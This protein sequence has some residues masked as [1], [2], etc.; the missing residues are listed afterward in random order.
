MSIGEVIRQHR[1]QLNLTQA[2]LAEIIGVSAQAI[3]KWETGAGMPDIFLLVPLAEALGITTDQL[4]RSTK[5]RREFDMLWERALRT[6]GQNGQATLA[7]SEAALAEFPRDRD[8][9]FRASWDEAQ[10]AKLTEDFSARQT[11]LHRAMNYGERLLTLEPNHESIKEHLVRVYDDLGFEEEAV[12]MAYRCENSERAL[13]WCLKGEDLRRHRLKII[14]R[15]LQ[16]LLNELIV[17]EPKLL[18][19]AEKL[20][21]ARE[22][23]LRLREETANP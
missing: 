14:D 9:L 13:K 12:A 20:R 6:P 4:L 2:Q 15:K 8:F 19:T 16:F 21:A 5:R 17:P 22:D 18:D 11:H 7:V 1:L 10:L 3:S 23:I